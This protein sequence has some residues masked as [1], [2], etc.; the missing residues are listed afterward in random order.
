MANQSLT[1]GQY[2]PGY[3]LGTNGHL[4]GGIDVMSAKIPQL[5]ALLTILCDSEWTW[6]DEIKTQLI[7]LARGVAN[8]I[9]E[10]HEEELRFQI[11]ARKRAA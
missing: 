10:A 6:N 3:V 4:D 9:H 7:H 5:N 8:D 2:K 11:T 1:P